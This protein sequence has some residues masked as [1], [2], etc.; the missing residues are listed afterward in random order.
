MAVQV[1]PNS[2]ITFE[3]VTQSPDT[4]VPIPGLP[5]FLDRFDPGSSVPQQLQGGQTD[6]TGRAQLI[7]EAPTTPGSYKYR[8]RTPGIAE[9]YRSDVSPQLT[10]EV[11]A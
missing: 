9:K 1:P 8:A 2:R 4:L 7:T 10:I 5:I 3:A 6:A 11:V